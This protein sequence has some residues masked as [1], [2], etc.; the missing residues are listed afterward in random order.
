MAK[1]SSA[2]LWTLWTP[3]PKRLSAGS[4]KHDNGCY[5]TL[6]V[7]GA[8]RGIDMAGF[9]DSDYLDT[10]EV[11]EAFG[12]A[13]AMAREIMFLNDE[14]YSWECRQAADPDA[15]RWELMREWVGNHIKGTQSSTV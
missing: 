11:G 13:E 9:D 6:G 4:F 5:C 15:R 12:I 8:A 14:A 10:T 7:L 1:R 2:P 3:C